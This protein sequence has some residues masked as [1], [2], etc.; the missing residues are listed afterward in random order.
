MTVSVPEF[1]VSRRA[2]YTAAAPANQNPGHTTLEMSSGLERPEVTRFGSKETA[3]QISLSGSRFGH[4]DNICMKQRRTKSVRQQRAS[5]APLCPGSPGEPLHK[6]RR[7]G[8]STFTERIVRRALE[9]PTRV[10]GT[11][12]GSPGLTEDLKRPLQDK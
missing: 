8:A 12:S 5:T 6:S 9:S 11:H 4:I 3:T 1:F 10:A 2:S 7:C